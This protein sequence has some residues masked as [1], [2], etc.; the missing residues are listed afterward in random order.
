MEM[1]IS[2]V[3]LIY[4]QAVNSRVNK[5]CERIYDAAHNGYES[6]MIESRLLSAEIISTLESRGYKVTVA[7][8]KDYIPESYLIEFGKEEAEKFS[9]R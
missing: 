1:N 8:A 3:A 4:S 5:V 6:V 2:N 9:L 7:I